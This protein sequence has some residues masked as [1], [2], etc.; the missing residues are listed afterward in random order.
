MCPSACDPASEDGHCQTTALK[1]DRAWTKHKLL[2]SDISLCCF[3]VIFR[4]T[5]TDSSDITWGKDHTAPS[6]GVKQLPC[7][8]TVVMLHVNRSLCV[9]WQ[10]RVSVR[11]FCTDIFCHIMIKWY[12]RKKHRCKTSIQLLLFHR[13]VSVRA[14]SLSHCCGSPWHSNR[15]EPSLKLL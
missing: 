15:A 1:T 12:M 14:G 6:R 13:P 4:P 5:D 7:W 3:W 9:K 10:F 2:S 8:L 11:P